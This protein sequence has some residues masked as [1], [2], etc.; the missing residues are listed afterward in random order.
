MDIKQLVIQLKGAAT[1]SL[2]DQEIHPFGTVKDN[3]GR[4][5]KCFA[6]GQWKVYLDP[7]DMH[8][9]IRYVEDNPLKE[10]KPRQHWSFVV[11]WEYS[12]DRCVDARSA[13]K[14]PRR[15]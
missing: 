9:A 6:R 4:T 7:E 11:P 14:T 2:V 1:E 10:G 15:R 5:P 12:I 3:R 8:R 13:P